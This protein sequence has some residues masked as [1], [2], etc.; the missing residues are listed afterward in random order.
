MVELK[1]EVEGD[2]VVYRV[3]KDRPVI[4]IMFNSEDSIYSYVHLDKAIDSPHMASIAEWLETRARFLWQINWMNQLE[5]S[6]KVITD[7]HSVDLRRGQ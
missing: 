7:L 1:R 2:E 5:A 3:P 6:K 4:L